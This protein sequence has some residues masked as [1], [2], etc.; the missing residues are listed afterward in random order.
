MQW[1]VSPIQCAVEAR[2]GTGAAHVQAAAI[3]S[4]I[5]DDGSLMRYGLM[6][7]SYILNWNMG[8]L[9]GGDYTIRIGLEEGECAVGQWNPVRVGKATK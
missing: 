5:A 7:D 9:T 6:A 4:D 8:K 3:R 2:T 1:G